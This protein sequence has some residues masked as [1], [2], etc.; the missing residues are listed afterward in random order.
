MRVNNVN[1]PSVYINVKARDIA[2]IVSASGHVD[3]YGKLRLTVNLHLV[4]ELRLAL[5]RLCRGWLQLPWRTFYRTLC[6]LARVYEALT[7]KTLG[8]A[9]VDCARWRGR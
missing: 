9:I 4:P 3:H 1:S 7:R 6:H 2:D 5:L 8:V